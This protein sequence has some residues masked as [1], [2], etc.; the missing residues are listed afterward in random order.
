MKKKADEKGAEKFL[1]EVFGKG[2]SDA[3]IEAELVDEYGLKPE[4]AAELLAQRLR[5]PE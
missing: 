1:D 4:R 3:S 2:R 5:L